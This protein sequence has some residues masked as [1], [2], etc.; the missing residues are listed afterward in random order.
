MLGLTWQASPGYLLLV[1]ACTFV[2]GLVPVATAWATK[3]LLD[4]VVA[5]QA[6]GPGTNLYAML[7]VFATYAGVLLLGRVAPILDRYWNSQLGRSL[8]I[9]VQR[10]V[11]DK[12]NKLPG[13]RYFED[14]AFHDTL[15]VAERGI[16]FGPRGALAGT[17]A[18]VR[19][20][21][22]L[23]SFVGV[24]ALIS[25]WLAGLVILSIMPQL[26]ME[27]RFGRQRVTL[28]ERTSSRLRRSTYY[29]YL[30]SGVYAAK[31]IRAFGL[32]EFLLGR[33]VTAASEMHR[34]QRRQEQYEARWHVVLDAV[35][36]SVVV[37]GLV[38]VV[39][40]AIA[41]IISIGDIALFAAAIGGTANSLLMVLRAV[42]QLDES[43]RFYERYTELRT[44]PLEITLAEQPVSMAPLAGGIEIRKVHFRYGG[45]GPPVLTDFSLLIPEGKCLA[46]VGENGAGKSTLVKLLTRMYDPLEGQILWDGRDI[47]EFDIDEYRKR[48]AVVFQ[49]YLR[50]D[51]TAAENI[52]V[53]SIDRR[54][55]RDLIE[56]AAK[57][58][59]IDEVIG[60]LEQGYDTM[61]GRTFAAT[62]QRRGAD[63]S[64]G[65]WQ[66]MAIARAYVR[67]AGFI[68]LD[69]PTASLDAD[70]EELVF[71][72]FASLGSGRTSLLISHRFSTIRMADLIAVVQNGRVT[73][74]GTHE[75]LL[76][77]RGR[78]KEL[79]DKHVAALGL[80]EVEA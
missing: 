27:L 7:P 17:V 32:G 3:L 46:L 35:S 31:E 47:R 64:G 15:Q 74:Y 21:L 39:A 68:I 10:V 52:A 78:Y 56:E 29:G 67:G 71:R 69:E 6:I 8:G 79:F 18:L 22:T 4:M 20:S 11:Y 49:D 19:S 59:G 58:A 24:V 60:R 50:F 40:Q 41:G 28:A 33:F 25:P 62:G 48:V 57:R 75:Q 13:L 2:L 63:L 72:D 51:M 55:R 44:L 70:A 65:E 26:W 76:A 30:L 23:V 73:E 43:T 45:S 61:L 14:P 77:G 53:G 36:I 37:L 12:L 54:E 38:L 34:E 1:V 66:K 80:R 42:A 5:Y 9:E 16:Q